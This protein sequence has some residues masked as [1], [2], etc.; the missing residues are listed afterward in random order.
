MWLWEPLEH[1][2]LRCHPLELKWRN[3]EVARYWPTSSLEHV[4]KG[5]FCSSSGWLSSYWNFFLWP[6]PDVPRQQGQRTEGKGHEESS[7]S[8][9]AW[10]HCPPHFDALFW[11]PCLLKP[12]SLF[13]TQGTTSFKKPSLT[14]L[15]H[16][17]AAI[18]SLSV[19]CVNLYQS[20][21]HTP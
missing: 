19:S 21:N 8:L 5:E 2:E 15:L 7:D 1:L 17:M 10:S 3:G 12:Y 4:R 6:Q 13:K 9:C 18:I 11:L 14:L 16:C 20:T